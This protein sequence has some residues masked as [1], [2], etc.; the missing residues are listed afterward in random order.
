VAGG[1]QTGGVLD[2]EVDSA[3]RFVILSFKKWFKIKIRSK[4][5]IF[6][7]PSSYCLL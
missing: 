3:E 1:I 4:G 6:F 2:F 5:S 7:L